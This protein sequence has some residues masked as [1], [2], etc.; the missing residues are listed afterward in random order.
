MSASWEFALR[1]IWQPFLYAADTVQLRDRF[2]HDV[3]TVCDLPELIV[4]L[5]T[6]VVSQ[7]LLRNLSQGYRVRSA[8][9]SRLRG[10]INLLETGTRQLMD[11]LASRI[12]NAEAAN[13]CRTVSVDFGRLGA[14]RPA[15]HL[16]LK[17]QSIR[18]AE[19]KLPKGSWLC[20]HQWCL[21]AHQVFARLPHSA[22]VSGP[23]RRV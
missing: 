18:S 10:R 3:E 15:D 8:K 11:R 19:T 14:C 1:N 13:Q 6:T 22:L 9:L 20:W 5:L 7:R 17:W 12:A 4:R 2:G 21:T 16:R 23:L